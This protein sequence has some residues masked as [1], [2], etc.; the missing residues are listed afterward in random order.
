MSDKLTAILGV[1]M[2]LGLAAI[3]YADPVVRGV[4]APKIDLAGLLSG[5][6]AHEF[7]SGFDKHLAI[8]EPSVEAWTAV[9]WGLFHE[10]R[11]GVL[12]GENDWLFSKEEFEA[13][14]AATG[15]DAT[16]KAAAEAQKALAGRGIHLIVAIVPSK[17]RIYGENLQRYQWPQTLEP[18]YDRLISG[19]TGEGVHVVDLRPALLGVKA[20][21]PA[22]FRT[23]THWTPA[24]AEAAAGAIAAA[25]QQDGGVKAPPEAHRLQVSYKAP[26]SMD[27]DLLTFVSLGPVFRSLGPKP[28]SLIQPV[29]SHATEAAQNTGEEGGLFGEAATPVLLVGTSYSADERWGFANYLERDL[30]VELVNSAEKGSGPF[31]PMESL[32]K[33]QTLDEARPEWVIWEIPE[34]YVWM[35]VTKPTGGGA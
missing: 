26:Q 14:R 32:L 28:D 27:G 18:V 21:E 3:G 12:A 2:G 9:S 31:I 11:E 22:Y 33:G 25:I 29:F 13:P 8:R 5:R 35:S 7:S 6:W 1:V 24:G 23:D 30:G 15:V 4:D 17:T 34:R 10:G 16:L 20:R 19:L